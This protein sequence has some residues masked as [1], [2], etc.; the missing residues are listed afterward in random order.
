MDEAWLS[1]LDRDV[2]AGRLFPS[3]K[4]AELL[5]WFRQLRAS[6]KPA[7]QEQY[8]RLSPEEIEEELASLDELD[9]AAVTT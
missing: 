3:P 1:R 5:E 9:R 8:V 2:A 6:R 7:Q 4:Q